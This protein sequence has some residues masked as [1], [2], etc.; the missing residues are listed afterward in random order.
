MMFTVRYD[1]HYF[2]GSHSR[3]VYSDLTHYGVGSFRRET[4]NILFQDRSYV[5]L[6]TSIIKTK[7]TGID[8]RSTLLF[9][10]QGDDSVK[11]FCYYILQ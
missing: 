6:L 5:V 2:C 3:F 4:S 7:F 10:L 1:V 8:H 9:P 11:S